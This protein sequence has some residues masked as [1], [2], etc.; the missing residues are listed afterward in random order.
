[1]SA[2]PS[3]AGDAPGGV[4]LADL[5]SVCADIHARWDADMRSGK[6]LIALMGGVEN[7]D[8][9]VTRIRDALSLFQTLSAR[10]DTLAYMLHDCEFWFGAHRDGRVMME[11]CRA[12]LIEAGCGPAHVRPVSRF[13][14]REAL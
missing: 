10:I 14:G 8:P 9:R 4:G 12:A 7:Y 3:S 2:S 1:M 6:L 13:H 5:E 11:K